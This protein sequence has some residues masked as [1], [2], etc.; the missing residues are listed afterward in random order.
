MIIDINRFRN[1]II[2]EKF[3]MLVLT[4]QN[5]LLSR[6]LKKRRDLDK[7]YKYTLVADRRNI[8]GKYLM[9]VS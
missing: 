4:F 6:G 5:L 1:R 2:S 3:L 8:S 9:F 7:L